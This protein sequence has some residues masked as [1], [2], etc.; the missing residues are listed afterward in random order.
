MTTRVLAALPAAALVVATLTGV[1]VPATRADVEIPPGTAQAVP[2]ETPT[3]AS[4]DSGNADDGGQQ[5]ADAPNASDNSDPQQS[6]GENQQVA[7]DALDDVPNAEP[8][9]QGSA[10]T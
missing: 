2:T 3:S 8:V 6:P 1:T 7:S 10:T 9:G 5:S 4:A